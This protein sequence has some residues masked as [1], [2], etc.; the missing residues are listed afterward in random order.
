MKARPNCPDAPER[1]HS[2][3]ASVSLMGWK[4]TTFLKKSKLAS[5]ITV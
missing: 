1:F 4:V 3:T 2:L 5:P